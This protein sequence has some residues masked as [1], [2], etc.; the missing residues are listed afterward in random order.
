MGSK[1]AR[2]DGVPVSKERER[3]RSQGVVDTAHQIQTDEHPLTPV[4]HQ[5]TN[6]ENAWPLTTV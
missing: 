2:L 6:D 5:Q 3:V 4:N 1:P